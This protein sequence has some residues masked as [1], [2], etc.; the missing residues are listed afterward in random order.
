M[1]NEI[2][3]GTQGPANNYAGNAFQAGAVMNPDVRPADKTQISDEVLKPSEQ[4]DYR[5]VDTGLT[6]IG[7]T[8]QNADMSTMGGLGTPGVRMG[9]DVPGTQTGGVARNNA[10]EAGVLGNTADA[11]AGDN[12]DDKTGGRILN[13]PAQPNASGDQIGTDPMDT[14]TL[15]MAKDASDL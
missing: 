9:A 7:A 14:T 5:A 13:D 6:A 11:M 15:G 8:D 4:T 12:M 2:E 3:Q 1:N 10:N